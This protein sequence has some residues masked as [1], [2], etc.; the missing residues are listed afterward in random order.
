MANLNE[1]EIII[2]KLANRLGPVFPLSKL[3]EEPALPA[4]QTIRNL[5][6]L[7]RIP[8]DI[9]IKDGR[10]VLIITDRFLSWWAA[11]LCLEGRDSSS[12][13]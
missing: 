9:F 2:N 7:K 1:I 4:T 8:A 11:G 3:N 6:S 12:L 5:R 13:N 10:R